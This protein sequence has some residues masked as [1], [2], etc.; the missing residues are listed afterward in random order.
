MNANWR[1]ETGRL[2]RKWSE[3]PQRVPYNAS[4]MQEGTTSSAEAAPPP[5]FLD[6]RRFSAL[7]GR[8]WLEPDPGYG[9]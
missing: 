3:L 1:T 5:C 8:R 7:G 6:F 4:W 9:C 2:T